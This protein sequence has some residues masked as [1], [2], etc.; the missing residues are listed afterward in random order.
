VKRADGLARPCL[1]GGYLLVVAFV[2]VGCVT[3]HPAPTASSLPDTAPTAD[4]VALTDALVAWARTGNAA[5]LDRSAFVDEV[6]LGLGT[7]I[8]AVRT[9]DELTDPLAWRLDREA[10]RGYVGPFTALEQLGRDGDVTVSV[11]QHPHCASPPMDPPPGLGEHR[12][13][14]IQPSS[15]QSC[16]QWW[17]VDLFLV[18]DGRIG[19]ITLDLYEP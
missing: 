4:D 18:E 13:L 2:L 9:F 11:G 16:L 5:V 1:V 15:T 14:S 12:R 8:L 17:A 7:E 10:F 3:Q 19:A 6:A